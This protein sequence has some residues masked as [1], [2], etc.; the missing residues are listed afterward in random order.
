MT[1]TA[2]DDEDVE[3]VARLRLGDPS[4]FAT[5]VRTHT[6]RLLQLSRRLLSNEE[7]ARDAVQETFLSVCRKL[8]SFQENA[9]LSTWL[10]RITTN[11]CLMRLRGRRCR[12]EGAIDDLLP[13]FAED[14]SHMEPPA[15]WD[16]RADCD[17]VRG[18]TRMLVR[19]AIERLPEPYRVVLVLRD[20][21]ERDSSEVAEI[22]GITGNAVKVRLHRARQALRT[23]L[24]DHFHAPRS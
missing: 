8:D 6:G 7:D 9:R 4:A 13:D 10:Y 5:L 1:K 2:P 12:P 14:G 3:L 11:A 15:P 17:V 20:I 23:L 24:D 16:A 22:L 21:E 19:A 18:E